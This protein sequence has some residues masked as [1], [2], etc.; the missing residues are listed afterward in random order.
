MTAS[1]YV[2]VLHTG[3][4]KFL[5]DLIETHF[6]ENREV[7]VKADLSY[8][9]EPHDTAVAVF[10]LTPDGTE[11]DN[12]IQSV[13]GLEARRLPILPV[14]E[15]RKKYRFQDLPPSLSKLSNL[16]AI[17]WN[18]GSALGELVIEAIER[19]LGFLPFKKDQKVF[20]SY[21]QEDGSEVAHTIFEYLH[22]ND[23]VPFLDSKSIQG[24]EPIQDRILEEITQRDLILLIDSPKAAESEWVKKEI[25]WAW[26][27][28]VAVCSLVLP[29]SRGFPML[30][31]MPRLTWDSTDPQQL[32]KLDRFISRI[33][34]GK[35]TFDMTV[36]RS[37]KD[38]ADLCGWELRPIMKRQL[39]F[40]CP[41]P[42][43][44][45]LFLVEYEDAPV[46]LE[47]LYRLYKAF[48]SSHPQLEAA[49]FI[50]GGNELSDHETAAV[51]WA[52]GDAPLFPL[53][54]KQIHSNLRFFKSSET[55]EQSCRP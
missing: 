44:G 23:W 43:E 46:T 35:A 13:A 49:F 47:R 20:I 42:G 22:A 16:L 50:H 25:N 19:Y 40:S 3:M 30:R 5:Y 14:V 41:D 4:G 31:E 55:G 10:V 45:W 28:R 1:K 7:Q 18:E 29:G 33:I 17:G 12:L 26:S 54:V 21:R 24:G 52:K 2:I 38:L 27:N 37:L 6:S 39:L 48:H 51:T 36:I 9:P 15:D 32:V 53:A 8:L 34:A 11:N